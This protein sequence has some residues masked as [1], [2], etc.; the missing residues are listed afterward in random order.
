MKHY[1]VL[2]GFK[3]IASKILELEGQQHFIGGG[4]ESY[5]YL[6]GDFVRDKDAV[7][8]TSLFAEAAAWAAEQGK[9]L[10]Q[11]LKDIYTEFGLYKEK[12]VSITKK[13]ISGTEEINAMMARFRNTPPTEIAG[14]KVIEIRDYKAQQ[15]R[16]LCDNIT[17]AL[18]L[19]KSDVLQFFTA[20][21][22]KVSV[23]PSGTEPKI[24]FYFSVKGEIGNDLDKAMQTLDEKL[25]LVEK[26]ICN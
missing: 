21:G 22:T 16:H 5:G 14:S 13:G 23:R 10:Y 24:K 9:T 25:T 2:T 11:V 1:D 20:D 19:P 8:A 7:I 17:S 26:E 3:Y 15:A 12:L 4:E 6:A 18:Q